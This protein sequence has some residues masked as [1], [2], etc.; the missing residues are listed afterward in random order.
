MSEEDWIRSRFDELNLM[1]EKRLKAIN[2]MHAYQR[3]MAR[4]FSKIHYVLELGIEFFKH[5]IVI[6]P[7]FFK[8]SSEPL[9]LRIFHSF[10]VFINFLKNCPCFMGTSS[11]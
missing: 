8:A 7:Y 5:L 1:D 9:K 2:H 3:K 10:S 4:A 6:H 11:G